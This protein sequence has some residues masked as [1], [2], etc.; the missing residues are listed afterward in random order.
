M[1]NCPEV[2]LEGNGQS[3]MSSNLD[4]SYLCFSSTQILS[5]KVSII[6]IR[7][8]VYTLLGRLIWITDL[9]EGKLRI[10]AQM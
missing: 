6:S 3:D 10:Q 2:L 9:A 4:Q 1:P 7:P 8:L 5:G